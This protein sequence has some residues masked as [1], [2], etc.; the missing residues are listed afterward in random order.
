MTLYS[1]NFRV[2]PGFD[3]GSQGRDWYPPVIDAL[4]VSAGDGFGRNRLIGTESADVLSRYLE[5]LGGFRATHSPAIRRNAGYF[6]KRRIHVAS[7]AALTLSKY[8]SRER[9]GMR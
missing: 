5:K 6:T 9:D 7:Q 8:F 1:F 4:R 2:A 3:E